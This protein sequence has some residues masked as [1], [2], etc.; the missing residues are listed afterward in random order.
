MRDKLLLS[1]LLPA[2]QRT[3]EFRVPLDLTVE[4]A[5]S[6]VSQLLGRREGASYQAAKGV[7]LML[8]DA[9]GPQTGEELNPNETFRALVEQGVLVEGSTVALT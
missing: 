4:Q 5:A 8:C 2:T 7:D 1:V 6:L 9:H 3:Y